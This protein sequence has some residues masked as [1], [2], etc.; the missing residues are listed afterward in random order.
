M[1]DYVN[2]ERT[3]YIAIHLFQEVSVLEYEASD[4]EGNDTKLLIFCLGEFS[5]SG[6][7]GED[8]N[9]VTPLYDFIKERNLIFHTLRP[10]H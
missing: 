5:L 3:K 9:L 7:S 1:W 10:N 2:D 6:H 4:P 8:M